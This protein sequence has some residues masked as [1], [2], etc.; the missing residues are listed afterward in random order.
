MKNP[1]YNPSRRKLLTSAAAA[2]GAASLPA[3]NAAGARLS[4]G[5]R[6]RTVPSAPDKDPIPD[7]EPIRVGLIGTGGMGGAHLSN[8]LLQ[9][10]EGDE[11]FQVVALADVNSAWLGDK[12]ERMR[13]GQPGVGVDTYGD[14]R[15]L[16]ARDDVDCVLIAAP[17]HWHATMAVDAIAA[18]KDVY[19][20]KPMTLSLDEAFWMYRT[21]EANPHMRLQ[22]GTQF[23]THEKYKAA[24]RLIAEGAIG[25][26]TLSQ[27]SYCRNTPDGEWNY[28]PIDPRV[29]P[30][31]TLD[32]ER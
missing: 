19:C 13:A 15:D 1:P 18:G 4:V 16:L 8:M 7:S 17:E 32:W 20:E 24:K 3:C 9:I 30:G 27:T 22:V 2:A 6:G 29:Q 12:A 14:Y 23:M 25:Y 21:M 31:D 26:P 11:N 10:E 5:A 28:Y